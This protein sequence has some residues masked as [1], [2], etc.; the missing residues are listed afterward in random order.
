MTKTWI[1]N[2]KYRPG[3]QVAVKSICCK[4]LESNYYQ[5]YS[6]EN[7]PIK[8]FERFKWIGK[9]KT[10]KETKKKIFQYDS[11]PIPL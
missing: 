8:L 11:S 5:Y 1:M 3:V 10:N 7:K 4:Q 9:I 6:K 2:K